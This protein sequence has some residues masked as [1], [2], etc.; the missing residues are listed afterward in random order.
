MRLFDYLVMTTVERVKLDNI[1]RGYDFISIS[2]N[3]NIC[4]YFDGQ[5]NHSVKVIEFLL[6]IF[7]ITP[8]PINN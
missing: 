6:H 5:F 3:M 2:K 1:H 8:F 7:E 4:S